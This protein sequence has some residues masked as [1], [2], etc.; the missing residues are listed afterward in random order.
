MWWRINLIKLKHTLKIITEKYCFLWLAYLFL[1]VYSRVD[2]DDNYDIARNSY[3]I[4]DDD[5]KTDN[6]IVESDTTS[7]DVTDFIYPF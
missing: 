4:E 7:D 1:I 3:L 2:M 6:E 5:D